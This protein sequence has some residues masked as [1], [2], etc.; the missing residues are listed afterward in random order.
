MPG[1]ILKDPID[2]LDLINRLVR[3]SGSHVELLNSSLPWKIDSNFSGVLELGPKDLPD[4]SGSIFLIFDDGVFNAVEF[5]TLENI[6]QEVKLILSTIG[7]KILDYRC[8]NPE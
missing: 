6:D 3:F 4:R 8:F 2:T 7:W 5:S 1:L